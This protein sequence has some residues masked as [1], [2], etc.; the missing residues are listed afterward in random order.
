M[1]DPNYDGPRTGHVEGLVGYEDYNKGDATSI[2]G[3]KVIDDHTVSFTTK[4]VDAGAIWNCGMGILPKSVYGFEKGDI[5]KIKDKLAEPVGAGPYKF[6]HYK[7]SQE[8]KVEKND[9]YYEGAPKIP[10]IV[11]KVTTKQTEIQELVSGDR[12]STRLNSSHL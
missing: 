3:L 5:Q 10:N 4:E 11:M 9:S 12:K 1:A 8:I 2:E 7:P 6:V